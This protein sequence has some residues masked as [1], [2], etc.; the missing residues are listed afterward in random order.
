[1]VSDDVTVHKNEMEVLLAATASTQETALS[2][3]MS[4]IL[5]R[6]ASLVTTVNSRLNL[7]EKSVEVHEWYCD[8]YH[9]CQEMITDAQQQL[10]QIQDGAGDGVSAVQ[11]QMDQL[12]VCTFLLFVSDCLIS[13]LP[14]MAHNM[15]H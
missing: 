2:K 12:K 13:L 7:L 4:G 14:F 3:M 11:Q 1:V 6:Y 8:N 10:Q 15:C 9:Q 5:A